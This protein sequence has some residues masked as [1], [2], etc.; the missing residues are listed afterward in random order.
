MSTLIKIGLSCWVILC[1]VSTWAQTGLIEGKVSSE[2]QLEVQATIDINNGLQRIKTDEQGRYSLELEGEKVYKLSFSVF[3]YDSK[4]I[5]YFLHAGETKTLNVVLKP[6]YKVTEEVDVYAN[7]DRE[8][9]GNIYL[10][11]S[12]IENI[13][14]A[15]GGVEALIKQFVGSQN[16]MTSQ[17]NVRGG[18]FDENLV[19]IND[20]EVYRP[21]LVQSGQ[22]EGLS[23]INP[24]LVRRVSFSTGGFQAKYRDK[25]SSVLDIEYKKPKNFAGSVTLSLL[26]QGMHLEG[27]SKNQKLSYLFGARSK[28]NQYFLQSQPIQGVYNPSFTDIQLLLR[29]EASE[30]WNMEFFGNYARNKFHFL[31][32]ESSTSFGTFDQTFQVNTIFTGSE[33]DN[34]NSTYAGISGTYRPSPKSQIKM[35]LSQ[36]RTNESENFDIGGEYL[37][38]AVSTDPSNPETYGKIIVA[39][40]AGEIQHFARNRLN[41]DVTNFRLK[42]FTDKGNHFIQYGA[43]VSYTIVHDFLK[44]WERRDSAGFSQPFDIAPQFFDYIEAENKINY[45]VGSAFIQD[46]VKF[47]NKYLSLNYGLRVTYQELNQ[48]WLFSPRVQFSYKIPDSNSNRDILLR[49]ATGIYNQPNFYREMRDLRGQIDPYLKAQKS[50][51]IVG[52]MDYNF[53]MGNRPFK[54]TSEAYYKLM[55]DMIPYEFDNIRIRY[56]GQNASN[57]FAVGWDNRLYGEFVPGA[58]SW[59]SMGLMKTSEDIVGDSIPNEN[60]GMSPVGYIPRPTDTRFN[61]GM[62]FQ[63]YLRGNKNFKVH[64]NFMYSTGLPT[65]PPNHFRADDTLRLPAYRR[66]DLGFSALL[67]DK[68]RKSKPYYSMFNKLQSIWVSLEVFNLI[69]YRNTLSY[70]WLSDNQSNR[71]YFV[72]NQLTSRLINLKM[73]VK[74]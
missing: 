35:L 41:I 33:L 74:F 18:N 55:W 54:F 50:Y 60:G 24:D 32:Q 56:F 38:G 12:E 34:F 72:P 10:D 53:K 48:E 13:P 73:V 26:G 52:G 2:D 46:N 47:T 69:G 57:A 9:A 1:S 23:I 42:A 63:D 15:V 36:Y 44:E 29:Y 66:I 3:G 71:T 4:S 7:R 31:P 49:I 51:Q 21:Y 39:L 61:F 30:K 16:E 65:G 64:L 70:T 28:T 14:T 6:K 58:Q 59:I 8:Q 67:L 27:V 62:F 25:M 5:N 17:Y 43:D 45:F 37:I 22:Q 11:A 19:Y 68:N 20:F 40:G